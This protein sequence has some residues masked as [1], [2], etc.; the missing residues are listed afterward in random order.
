MP[1]KEEMIAALK[2]VFDPDLGISIVDLGLVYNVDFDGTTAMI[3]MTLTTPACPYGPMLIADA[4][5]AI[6]ELEQV[7]E[8]KVELVW[9]PP[10]TQDRLSDDV[11]LDLGLDY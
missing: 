11:K 5:K 9:D 1:S 4:K 8:A 2:N 6:E 3:D 10:W 7:T